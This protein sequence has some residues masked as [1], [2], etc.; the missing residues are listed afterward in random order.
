MFES[1][2]PQVSDLGTGNS[3]L[4]V[5]ERDARQKSAKNWILLALSD[6]DFPTVGI[7]SAEGHMFKAHV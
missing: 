7:F 2:M 6:I 3:N 1:E 4:L 5:S